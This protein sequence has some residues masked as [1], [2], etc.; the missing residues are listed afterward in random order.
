MLS[1]ERTMLVSGLLA[2]MKD[3]M[4]LQQMNTALTTILYIISFL[5]L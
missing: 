3:S 5:D 2:S 4:N 1:T